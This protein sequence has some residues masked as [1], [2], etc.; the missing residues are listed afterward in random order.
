MNGRST[1]RLG[2]TLIELLVVIAIIGII[3]SIAMVALSNARARGN[4]ANRIS[5]LKELQKALHLYYSD[6]GSYPSTGNIPG[7][8]NMF[9]VYA[10][11]GCDLPADLHTNDWIPG[12]VASGYIS[13]LPKD[14]HQSSVGCYQYASDGRL[15]ILSAWN[16]AE[17]EYTPTTN[18][19]YSV[20]GFREYHLVQDCMYN[21]P[22]IRNAG[23]Y[24]RS[25]TVTNLKAPA[26]GYGCNTGG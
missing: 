26:S 4:D 3:A 5:Q 23:F 8:G 10:P 17:G 16:A 6:H 21:H 19:L 11:V 1:Y 24:N 13:S 2:F 7:S 12:L 20:A 22:N 25:F 18:P 15:Y 14:P 9:L